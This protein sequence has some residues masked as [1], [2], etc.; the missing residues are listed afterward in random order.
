MFCLTKENIY[1]HKAD[2]NVEKESCSEH[3]RKIESNVANYVRD[4]IFGNK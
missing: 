1:F 3:V 2:E 4:V